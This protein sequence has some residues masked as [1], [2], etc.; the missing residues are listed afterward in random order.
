MSDWISSKPLSRINLIGYRD[1]YH[2]FEV[3]QTLKDSGFSARDSK[4]ILEEILDGREVALC[5]NDNTDRE[6]FGKRLFTLG[7]SIGW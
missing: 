5:L 6:V 1:G 7:I 4:K 3:I 2:A